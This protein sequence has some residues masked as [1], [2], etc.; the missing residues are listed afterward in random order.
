MNQNKIIDK[1]LDKIKD[2]SM[3]AG[4]ELA[5]LEYSSWTGAYTE[6]GKELI[7]WG[8]ELDM[9]YRIAEVLEPLKDSKDVFNSMENLKR[10]YENDLLE[11]RHIIEGEL[12]SIEYDKEEYYTSPELEKLPGVLFEWLEHQKRIMESIRFIGILQEELAKDYYD[13][14]LC[15]RDDIEEKDVYSDLGHF[16]NVYCNK[17]YEI[18]KNMINID[19]ELGLASKDEYFEKLAYALDENE[20]LERSKELVDDWDELYEK[21][22]WYKVHVEGEDGIKRD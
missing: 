13:C 10:Y 4:F 5:D 14:L 6:T 3:E 15:G 17:C 16:N 19:D 7:K 9:Y 18:E 11:V 12:R 22:Y 1:W 8:T 20:Y 21:E 2:H